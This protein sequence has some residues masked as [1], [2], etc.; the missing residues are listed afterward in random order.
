MKQLIVLLFCLLSWKGSHLHA[1]SECLP[2]KYSLSFGGGLA[3]PAVNG[4][5]NDFFSKNGNRPGYN[6][7]TEGR[8]Y[9]SPN[10]ATGAQYDYLRTA[11]GQDKMH[12]HFVRPELVLR[13]LWSQGNQAAFF[14]LGIGYLDYQ[15]RTYTQGQRY[16]HLYHKGYCGISFALG[17][18]FRIS[19][20]VSG[21]LRAEA[22]TADWFVNPEARLFN[23]DKNYDD[24]INHQWF[25]SHITFINLGFGVQFGK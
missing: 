11:F 10:F 7:M 6:L 13:H 21:V 16:G 23:P 2:Q 25:K 15:E 5:R 12:V 20:K 1:Q 19:R 14:S 4:N 3:L 9:F 8:Y 22:L 24:G 18:E 17:W